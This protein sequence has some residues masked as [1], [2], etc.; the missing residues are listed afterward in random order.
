MEKPHYHFKSVS[1]LIT[2]YNRSNSLERLLTAFRDLNCSFGGIIVSDDGSKSMHL[3]KIT[4][5]QQQFSFTLVTTPVNKGLGNNINK[6]QDAVTTPYTLYVQEDFIPT[7][8]FPIHFTDALE[9]MEADPQ[10]DIARFYAYFRYPYIRTYNKGFSEMIFHAAP[11]YNNHL[12]FYLY[13]DHPHLRRS[14]FFSKFGRYAEGLSGDRTEYL[15]ALAFIRKK[16]KGIFFDDFT[17]LF[18]QAN[19]EAE[20]STMQRA[21]WRESK[22]PFMLLLRAG[23]LQFKLLKWSLD[24]ITKK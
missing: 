12:K 1:L 24:L 10:L 2:H 19:S 6:G 21:G 11:W 17:K 18:L 22:N 14:N 7:G 9:M 3:E 8:I 13:S 20:P 15:M 16:A 4:E 23:Y 5:L